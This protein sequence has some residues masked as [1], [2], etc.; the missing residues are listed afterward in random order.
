AALPRSRLPDALRGRVHRE[1]QAAQGARVDRARGRHDVAR[2][3]LHFAQLGSWTDPP[4]WHPP[5]PGAAR[6]RFRGREALRT[7]LRLVSGADLSSPY[8]YPFPAELAD[9]PRDRPPAIEASAG[10]GQTYL[11]GH[12][13]VDRVV[14]HGRRT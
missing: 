12:I 13:L 9:L 14:V 10:T 6:R 5:L 11:I 1:A 2:R 7:V 3:R 4:P 8:A